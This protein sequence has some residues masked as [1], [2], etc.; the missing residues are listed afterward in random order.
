MSIGVHTITRDSYLTDS[1]VEHLAAEAKKYAKEQGK[2]RV[3]VWVD[4]KA[5]IRARPYL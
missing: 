1:Q 3:A 4:G 2:N 5:E